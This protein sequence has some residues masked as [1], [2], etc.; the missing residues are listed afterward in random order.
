MVETGFG[1][2]FRKLFQC[3]KINQSARL[4]ST[5]GKFKDITFIAVDI[6]I[7]IKF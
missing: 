2:K 3:G 6:Q 7:Q 1:C 5:L 4:G